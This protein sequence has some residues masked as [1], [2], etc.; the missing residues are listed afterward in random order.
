[1][2]CAGATVFSPLKR[3]GAGPGKKV[4]VVGIGGLGY[5]AIMFAKALRA[6]VCAISR[7][8]A[9]EEDARRMG[10]DDSLLLKVNYVKESLH[11]LYKIKGMKGTVITVCVYIEVFPPSVIM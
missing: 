4:G 8:R 2:M 6:E 10:A 1:M 11:V 7:T 3:F 5:Y 9:K